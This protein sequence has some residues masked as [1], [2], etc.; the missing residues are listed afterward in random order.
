[1]RG[2]L[3]LLILVAFLVLPAPAFAGR[4]IVTGHDADRRCALMDQQCGFLKATLK[5]VRATAP[6]P[7]KP[8][9]V[10]D[11]SGKQLAT[12]I[13][14]AWGGSGYA[15]VSAAAPPLRVVD[16]RSPA[17]AKLKIDVR[18]FSVIAIA[19]DSSCGGCDLEAADSDAIWKRKTVLQKFLNQG[20]GIF[21]GAGGSNAAAYYRFMPVPGTGPGSEGPFNVT[22]YG[23]R[24]GLKDADLAGSVANTFAPPDVGRMDV[25]AKTATNVG[26]TLIADGR[27]RKGKLVADTTIPPALGQSIV[28][29]PVSGTVLGHP[30]DDPVFRRIVG[31]ANLVSG[32]TFDVTKGRVSLTTAADSR[33]GLQTTQAY[34]GFFT[35]LQSSGSAVTDLVLRSGNFDAICGSG[36]VDVARASANTKSVRHLWASGSGKFRTKGRFAAASV[37]G[38]EWET[39][40]RCDGTLITVKA[41]AVSVFDQVLQK[42]IVVK[43]GK[44]YLAKAS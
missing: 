6:A 40:D 28:V 22:A 3:P 38:T 12:A 27:V 18:S 9:L 21:A 32:W 11:R 16:P 10:L 13:R 26:D 37:R 14:K 4:L 31:A 5:Y 1:V 25:A 7:K 34:E 2:R 33:G 23:R 17:F 30:P 8:V 35:A 36:G 24:I 20:G 41:G 15:R 39:D 29:Q 19:S 42:T 43:A 44:S